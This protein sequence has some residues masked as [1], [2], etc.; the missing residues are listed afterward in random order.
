M[1]SMAYK[2]TGG[3][4]V[5][6][7]L[8]FLLR[9][10]QDMRIIDTETGLAARG[11]PISFI[12][13]GAIVLA[14]AA[15][16]YIALRLRKLDAPLTPEAALGGRTFVYTVIGVV[17]AA[18]LAIAGAIELVQVA[19]GVWTGADRTIRLLCGVTGLLAALGVFLVVSGASKPEKAGARRFGA[20]TVMLY[21]ALWIIAIYKSASY[22]P[23][24]WRFAVE[25]VAACTAL[26]AFFY[27]AGYFFG[28]PKPRVSVFLCYFGAFMCV[29]SIIDEHSA[30]DSL[31]YAAVALLLFF[32][33]HAIV[34]N[35]EPAPE[36]DTAP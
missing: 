5:A 16:L 19:T 9:W 10:L 8:G 11:R 32:W 1:R 2:L 36:P 22:D 26:L 28:E 29:M 24:V 15:L 34:S 3:V 18:L 4:A 20:V 33:G 27:V 30:A 31:S 13:A 7:A 6:S 14:A 25:V 21:G 12:V 17:P 35:L 23:V